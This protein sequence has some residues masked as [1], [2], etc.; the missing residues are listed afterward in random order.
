[1]KR[2]DLFV[3][4]KVWDTFHSR[5]KTKICLQDTLSKLKMDYIDLYLIHWPMGLKEDSSN[6]ETVPKDV[7]GNILFSD[8]HYLETYKGLEDLVEQGL[9]K[10]IG[11]SNFNIEQLKDILKNAKIKPMICQI[12]VNPYLQND[13]LIEFCQKNGV[14]VEGYAPFG[15]GQ[16]NEDRPELPLIVEHPTLKEIGAKYNKTAAQVC[17]RWGLQRNLVVIPKSVTPERI[18]ENAQVFDFSLT[19]DDMQKIKNLN[20]NLRTYSVKEFIDHPLYPFGDVKAKSQHES[21]PRK[22]MK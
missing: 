5:E 9:V 1:V 3:T 7:K 12:E 20:V 13:E 8:I 18:I 17:L 2:Q 14:C 19:D 4:S 15:T 16:K 21:R 6:M 10:S 11:V 22:T